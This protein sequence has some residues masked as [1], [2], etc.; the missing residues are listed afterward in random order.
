MSDKEYVAS[1][2]IEAAE[3]LDESS[4]KTKNIKKAKKIVNSF[5]KW[6]ESH[7]YEGDRKSGTIEVDG[8]KYDIDRNF[9]SKKVN[10]T[11]QTYSGKMEGERYRTTSSSNY[12]NKDGKQ[13]IVIDKAFM[14]LSDKDKDYLLAHEISHLKLHS[15]DKD[16]KHLDKKIISKSTPRELGKGS[17]NIYQCSDA[18][19]YNN[20]DFISYA[21]DLRKE[22]KKSGNDTDMK[23][24]D[25]NIKELG[26][27]CKNIIK[28]GH[29]NT[30]EG[31][32]D[33]MAYENLGDKNGK[34][35]IKAIKNYTNLLNKD[36]AQEKT[37]HRLPLKWWMD[38]NQRTDINIRKKMMNDKNVDHS[39]YKK[40]SQN[41]CIAELLIE[42]A[43]LL[44][45]EKILD[46]TKYAGYPHTRNRAISHSEEVSS[47][48]TSNNVTKE[49]LENAICHAR[50][51]LTNECEIN[52]YIN[53]IDN[54]KPGLANALRQHR[55]E[56]L[57]K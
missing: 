50:D 43:E 39:I 26:N 3:L 21:N 57:R 51:H 16:S 47:F 33:I 14:R 34:N 54:Y 2:L 25:K 55:K 20:K 9:S 19:K 56:L 8:E 4:I 42:A 6:L 22:N 44:S 29:T 17:N 40:K 37:G 27:N 10:S 38:P 12:V 30:C 5:D 52:R 7:N 28:N 45:D 24:R 48:N 46:E 18:N 32:A 1:L 41:E 15:M 53:N 49:E 35:M 13:P 36:T 31:E 23:I 11:I